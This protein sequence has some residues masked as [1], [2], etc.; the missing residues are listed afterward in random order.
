MA[1]KLKSGSTDRRSRKTEAAIE[2]A[3][4]EIAS[5]KDINKITVKD[6]TDIADI[7]RGTFYL[8][9]IDIL[10]LQD[11][12]ENH[13]IDQLCSLAAEDV[14]GSGKEAQT[15]KITHILEFI[16]QYKTIF[17][18][19]IHSGRSVQFID[20]LTLALES[21]LLPDLAF[22]M[23]DSSNEFRRRIGIFCT[24]GSVALIRDWLTSD[25]AASPFDFA[26]TLERIINM[27]I[28]SL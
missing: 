27:S 13:I 25:N 24:S 11:S 4:F 19:F 17:M 6:I 15:M 8:H 26:R 7:N 1:T 16:R 2:N 14:S 10:D 21:R 22:R 18:A 23:K 9:Y 3:F 5:K 20:K 12:I 28:S